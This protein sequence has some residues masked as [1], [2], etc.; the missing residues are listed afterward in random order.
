MTTRIYHEHEQTKTEFTQLVGLT[1]NRTL[2]YLI[3]KS[4]LDWREEEGDNY[5]KNYNKL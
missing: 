2:D 1:I 5:I 3:K 4:D